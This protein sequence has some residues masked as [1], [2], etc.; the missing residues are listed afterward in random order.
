MFKKQERKNIMSVDTNVEEQSLPV[1]KVKRGEISIDFL[2]SVIKRGDNRGDIY[3]CPEISEENQLLVCEW[4]TWEVVRQILQARIRI[5]CQDIAFKCVDKITKEFDVAKFI[6]YM[7][8]FSVRGQTI[9]ELEDLKDSL[10]AQ[11]VGLDYTK[12]ENF[13]VLQK[14]QT[15][16]VQVNKI[17]A[18]K[19]TESKIKKELKES[20]ERTETKESKEVEAS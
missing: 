3:P 14:L 7:Q 9:G 4:L 8:S 18:E 10:V 11:M 12:P 2:P 20:L 19:A 1:L 17:L 16:I 13:V 15:E 6:G 5:T